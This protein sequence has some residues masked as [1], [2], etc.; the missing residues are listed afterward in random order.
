MCQR[1]SCT[2]PTELNLLQVL[3]ARFG[4]DPVSIVSHSCVYSWLIWLA[5]IISP[6]HY[7]HK[8]PDSSGIRIHQWPTR[9]TLRKK[10]STDRKKV[11]SHELKF[12]NSSGTIGGYFSVDLNYNSS[13]TQFTDKTEDPSLCLIH[14][15]TSAFSHLC[16]VYKF[17]AEVKLQTE[18]QT[19]V[20]SLEALNLYLSRY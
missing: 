2:Q 18:V 6:A 17:H 11:N 14:T 13:F 10:M 3:D 15:L 8:I 5:T 12:P 1:N 9:V 16:I 20:L 19:P 4:V 7:S